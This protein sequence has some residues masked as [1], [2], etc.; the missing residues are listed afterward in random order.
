MIREAWYYLGVMRTLSKSMR[1][2]AIAD[3][4]MEVRSRIARRGESFLELARTR[5]FSDPSNPFH[6]MFQ[7]AGC[8]FGDLE[9]AVRNHGL[10]RALESLASAGV[11][12]THDEFKGRAPIV[13]SGQ[14]IEP[15]AT[16]FANPAASRYLDSPSSGSS[17]KPVPTRS[18]P[19]FLLYK[20]VYEHLRQRE[21]GLAGRV[22]LQVRPMLPSHM[23]IM[24]SL[25]LWRMG[26]RMSA[27]FTMSGTVRDSGHYR[28]MT[29]FV[30]LALKAQGARIPWPTSLPPN[31][32]SPAAR[33]ISGMK[34][35]GRTV[36]VQAFTSPAVRIAASAR[37]SNLDIAGTLFLVGGEALTNAKRAVIEAAGCEVYSG[38]YINEVGPIGAGCRHMRTGNDVHLYTDSVAAIG[39]RRCAP[40][41]GV[42]VDSL[43]FTTLLE[44]APRFLINTEMDDAGVI[45]P[46]RCDCSYSRLG[47]AIRISNVAS[48]GKLTGQGMTLVGTDILR[49]LEEALPTRFGGAPGDYQ[50]LEV[51]GNGQTQLLLRASPRLGL[52]D[53]DR[54]KEYFLDKVRGEYGGTLAARVWRHA[55]A[56]QVEIAEPIRSPGG[57]VLPLRLLRTEGDQSHAS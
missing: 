31:D 53:H 35:C 15:S 1:T 13:R 21:L 34:A 22:H 46:A 25:R 54:V 49:I 42:E 16:S 29:L 41:S 27:W 50:L 38:Y 19:E 10:E 23:G 32:F 45:G 48:F 52:K 2:P 56:V 36:V 24:P 55:S 9:A 28:A 44:C 20:E 8:E 33:W 43:A 40:L 39:R 47:M 18:S 4:E 30:V 3:P 6:R 7:L 12:L 14:A 11:Y 37:E 51:E 17:G 57:K 26:G 5:V